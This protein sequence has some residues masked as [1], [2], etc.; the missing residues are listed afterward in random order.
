MYWHAQRLVSWVILDPVTLMIDTITYGNYP[1]FTSFSV[2]QLCQLCRHKQFNF[3]FSNFSN[4]FTQENTSHTYILG[5]TELI[6][7]VILN[8]LQ[9]QSNLLCLLHEI[10][11]QCL[12]TGSKIEIV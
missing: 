8:L 4:S 7:W 2:A 10:I 1:S 12:E 11:T 5:N 6:L 9:M 3:C